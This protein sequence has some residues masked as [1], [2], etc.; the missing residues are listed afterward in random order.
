MVVLAHTDFH[1][2]A[3]APQ[4]NIAL[5]PSDYPE[6]RRDDTVET[7]HGMKIADPYRWLEDPDS[8]ETVACAHLTLLQHSNVPLWS[9][10]K[11]DI[12]VTCPALGVCLSV[13]LNI[14]TKYPFHLALH[15]C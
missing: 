4:G 15:S 10:L 6:V 11:N 8:P 2:V 1:W 7:L 13:N 12:L 9:S 5:N 3:G 14:P